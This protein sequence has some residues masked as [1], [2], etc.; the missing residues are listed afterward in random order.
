[1]MAHPR[2]ARAHAQALDATSL[3]ATGEAS[4]VSKATILS[5]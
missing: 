4:D 5:H 3:D 1:M 2:S